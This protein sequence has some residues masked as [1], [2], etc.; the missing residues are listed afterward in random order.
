[1]RATT[2]RPGISKIS[3][4][5]RR[6]IWFAAGS[7]KVAGATSGTRGGYWRGGLYEPVADSGGQQ[8]CARRSAVPALVRILPDLWADA[9]PEPDAWLVLH[10]GCLLRGH[11]AGARRELLAGRACKRR[12]NGRN[13]RV[14]RAL[15][16]APSRRRAAAASAADPRVR[17][18]H[19]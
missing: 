5:P 16:A 12:G 6:T 2:R 7:R 4:A 10:A 1:M 9:H 13:R 14:D 8:H 15:P 11:A 17:L 3:R 18:R 19:Q